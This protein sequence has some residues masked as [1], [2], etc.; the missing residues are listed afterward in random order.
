[1]TVAPAVQA[2]I[3]GVVD[4][5]GEDLGAGQGHQAVRGVQVQVGDADLGYRAFGQAADGAR[6]EL[7]WGLA[8]SSSRYPEKTADPGGGLRPRDHPWTFRQA[9]DPMPKGLPTG[10]N[11]VPRMPLITP[12]AEVYQATRAVKMP[13]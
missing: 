4:C 13:T 12:A 11:G 3:G 8:I 1:M 6:P 10:M 9:V 7:D 5:G 2:W